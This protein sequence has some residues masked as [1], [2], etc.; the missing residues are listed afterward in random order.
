MRGVK[1]YVGT[2]L[3]ESRLRYQAAHEAQ[4][5]N[6]HERLMRLYAATGEPKSWRGFSEILIVR[7][8]VSGKMNVC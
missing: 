4:G 2:L 6:L 8:R 5:S 7:I 1:W 3:A